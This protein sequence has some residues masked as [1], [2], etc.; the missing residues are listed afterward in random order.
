MSPE[1]IVCEYSYGE[2]MIANTLSTQATDRADRSLDESASPKRAQGRPARGETEVGKNKIVEGMRDALRAL[3]NTNVSRKDVARH[4][5]VTPAL[6]TY[7]FPER[8]ALIAAATSPVVESLVNDVKARLIE[9]GSTRRQLFKAIN[10]LL[11]CYAR[12]A[13][14]IELFEAQMTATPSAEVPDLLNDLET[15]LTT[16]FKGWID[17][18]ASVADADFLQ[19]AMI[20]TCKSVA[21]L[22]KARSGSEDPNDP[23]RLGV[24][25]MVCSMLL[26]SGFDAEATQVPHHA[27]VED[28]VC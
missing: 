13:V 23:G 16:F 17:N 24:A 10:V 19:K 8:D 21:D 20:G 25:E 2:M 1:E 11:E 5:G 28:L 4:A 14:I 12:D 3:K 26:G 18:S 7:Y 15:A 22:A 9:A 27:L 6:V